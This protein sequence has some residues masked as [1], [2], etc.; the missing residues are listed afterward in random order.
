VIFCKATSGSKTSHVAFRVFVSGSK[1]SL[2]GKDIWGYKV[3]EESKHKA[4]RITYFDT[5]YLDVIGSTVLLPCTA[6]G[7]GE[8][9]T[10]W[11]N[12][13]EFVVAD[14]SDKRITITPFGDLKIKNIRWSDMGPYT[15][16]ARNSYGQ[17]SITTFLYPLLAEK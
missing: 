3:K 8:V 15:C 6:S 11:L 9:D 10:I 14:G 5:T 2:L 17:D 4:P 1:L 16:L 13:T 12:A 7:A